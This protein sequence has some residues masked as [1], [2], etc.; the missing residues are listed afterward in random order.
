MEHK[1]AE[2]KKFIALVICHLETEAF[3][4]AFIVWSSLEII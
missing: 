1:R 2:L 4:G 3:R